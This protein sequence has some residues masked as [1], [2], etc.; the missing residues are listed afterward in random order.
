MASNDED[1]MGSPQSEGYSHSI[2]RP[3]FCDVVG[4]FN[5]L[6][7]GLMRESI[8]EGFFA[9]VVAASVFGSYCLCV[10]KLISFGSTQNA[11]RLQ[12]CLEA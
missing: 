7:D 5:S 10:W 11:T 1:P 4:Q 3:M 8:D 2:S 9:D 6:P 12:T